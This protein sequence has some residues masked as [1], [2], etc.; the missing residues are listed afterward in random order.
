MGK[1][2]LEYLKKETKAESKKEDVDLGLE[3]G[4]GLFEKVFSHMGDM[5]QVERYKCLGKLIKHLSK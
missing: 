2:L 3:Y 4:L 1:D 5:T